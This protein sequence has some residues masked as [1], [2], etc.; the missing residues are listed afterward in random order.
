MLAADVSRKRS[1]S[2]PANLFDEDSW[3]SRLPS[4]YDSLV[5]LR[6]VSVEP[7]CGVNFNRCHPTRD[8]A[9]LLADIV[10]SCA[11]CEGQELGAQIDRRLPPKPSR[12]GLA[13]ESP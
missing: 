7:S 3:M 2:G 10:A 5:G 4:R 9:H 8:V 13:V 1:S 11:R 6:A 12:A